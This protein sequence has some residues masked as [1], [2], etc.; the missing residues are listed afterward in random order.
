[1]SGPV[2]YPAVPLDSPAGETTGAVT[3][4]PRTGATTAT[5]AGRPFASRPPAGRRRALDA[6]FLDL[7]KA[8]RRGGYR[9]LTCGACRHFRYSAAARD[10]S[11]GLSGYCGLGHS[12]AG[13]ASIG[14][15]GPG[16]ATAPVVTLYFSCPDWD[17]RDERA[18]ADFFARKGEGEGTV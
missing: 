10:L 2:Q 18:L 8:L 17:G 11:A 15:A 14:P 6:S 3:V 13:P 9:L 12:E 7:R 16:G 1:M 5:V 4:D